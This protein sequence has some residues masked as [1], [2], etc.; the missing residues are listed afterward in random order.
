MG[1][2]GLSVPWLTLAIIFLTVYAV[3]MLTTL[4][5]ARRASRV[6]P[7]QALRYQ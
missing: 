3:A 7:A 2:L 4:V 1:N 5:P 6:F